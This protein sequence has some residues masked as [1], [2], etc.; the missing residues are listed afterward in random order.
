MVEMFNLSIFRGFGRYDIASKFSLV[1]K[2]LII[3][4]NVLLVFMG[5]GLNEFFLS[6]IGIM[7][8]MCIIEFVYVSKH[9]YK[10]GFGYGF[11]PKIFYQ[12]VDFA[13]WNWL[14]VVFNTLS[15]QVD[16]MAVAFFV[17]LEELAYYSIGFLVFRQ[18]YMVYQASIGWL[19]PSIS[20]QKEKDKRLFRLFQNTNSILYLG[21]IGSL[22]TLYFLSDLGLTL[23]L[24]A[25][26]A[27]RSE[28]YILLF[29]ALAG[30]TAFSYLPS[31]F[32]MG[33][34]R[35]KTN[36]LLDITNK[37]LNTLL[38]LLGYR[39]W[40]VEGLLFGLI[41]S[42][43]LYIPLQRLFLFRSIISIPASELSKSMLGAIGVMLYLSL[44][45]VEVTI[46]Q[47]LGVLLIV[48]ISYY[49]LS[50]IHKNPIKAIALGLNAIESEV[51]Q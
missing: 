32:F 30:L 35:A 41:L 42:Q 48:S 51:K 11:N 16:K 5:Y 43:C 7:A 18:L 40:G 27:Q 6:I 20:S 31:V 24:G 44:I 15:N 45:L 39:L 37:S 38:A 1:S 34:G 29:S 33:T 50:K 36:T 26:K 13:R 14:Q 12:V 9:F 10:F 22:L 4:S 25:E 17:G 21:V 28:F 23:W 49:I 47:W 46:W 2:L 3:G 19:F 8:M